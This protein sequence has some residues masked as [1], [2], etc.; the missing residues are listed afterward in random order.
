MSKA[1][2]EKFV[3]KL[4][5]GMC[6]EA[7]AGGIKPRR[8]LCSSLTSLSLVPSVVSSSLACFSLCAP[9]STSQPVGTASNN[10]CF[11]TLDVPP[12]L[13]TSEA[14]RGLSLLIE[15]FFFLSGNHISVSKNS[16]DITCI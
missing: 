12:G 8:F 5:P 7:P 13:R 16:S 1:L 2:A 10:P 14:N 4:N 11:L 15:C 6:A 9:P 3:V